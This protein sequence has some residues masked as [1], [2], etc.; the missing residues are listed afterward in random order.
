MA[1]I[2]RRELLKGA[3]AALVAARGGWGAAAA[4]G[5]ELPQGRPAVG[6]RH[7]T[8]AAVEALIPRVQQGIGDR[9]LR[10]IFENCF[11]N[12]LDTTVYPGRYE[13]KPDTFVVT[14]DISAMW[15]R[16][17][18]AQV[19]PYLPL[20]REDGKLRE[21]LEGVIRRQARMILIDPY[22][23][24]F[25]RNKTDGPLR[26]AR[27]DQ[28]RHFAGVGERK[29]EVDSLCYPIRL[30]HGY[31]KATGDTGPFDAQWKEAAWTIVRTFRTQQRKHGRGPYSFERKSDVPYDTV[32]LSGFGNPARPVGMI[33]SMF[34][35]SDDACIYPLFVPANKFAVVSLRQVA[36]LATQVLAD[37][38]LAAEAD[39]LAAEVER[40]VEQHGRT[41]HAGLGE[42]WAYEVDGYGNVLMMDDANAP[43]LLSL[44][45]LGCCGV[46]DAQYRRTREFVLSAS[47][48]Y[49][50]HGKAADG[51]GGPHE[52]LNMVWPMSITFRA[53]TSTDEQEI[54]QCLRW[55]RDT[56]AGTGFMHE[57]F[58]KD[59][60]GKYTRSWFAWANTLF[61][62]LVVKLAA[63]RPGLLA[64]ELG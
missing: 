9:A 42:I 2:S 39:E 34:R 12:T 43:G 62:E 53:L 1:G 48:P 27:H 16:D 5:L 18:S 37:A 41:H 51:V 10:T 15:L 54:R 32:A 28:T 55:L 49:Y 14:G 17:S 31:W 4:S 57:S 19:W 33:F 61:G 64:G 24:A 44:P 6:S 58:E 23:N 56:T 47:N 7:F 50:F 36:E 21:L 59:N 63:E 30:A 11:P 35:P 8:S 40:A 29:W 38:K 25:T 45:Y 60:A 22:A 46:A 52:G 3:G 20:A 13:G 26:W